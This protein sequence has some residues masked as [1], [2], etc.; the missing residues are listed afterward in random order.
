MRKNS[1][2]SNWY[3]AWIVLMTTQ[4]LR[5]KPAPMAEVWMNLVLI[6]ANS[7]SI[8]LE[9]AAN[10]GKKEEGD[11]RGS[12][13][14]DGFPAITTFIGIQ[15]IGIIHDEISDGV[16]ILWRKKRCK[17]NTAHRIPKSNLKL[18]AS[19]TREFKNAGLY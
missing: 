4:K 1:S 13:L 6:E 12:L 14:L 3:W 19:L 7:P 15:D 16:E 5:K 8:A 18:L 9:K 11:C 2:K 17:L 10:L